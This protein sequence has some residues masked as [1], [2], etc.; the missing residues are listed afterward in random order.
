M[1]SFFDWTRRL[2]SYLG[3]YFLSFL[4][5]LSFS[6]L[7]LNHGSW[8]F[9]QFWPQRRVSKYERAVSDPAGG[10]TDRA[11]ALMAQIGISGEVE[12]VV[13]EQAPGHL[14]FRVVRPG[15]NYEVDADFGRGAAAVEET[16]VNAWGVLNTLHHLNGVH[17]GDARNTRDWFATSLWVFCMDALAAGLLFIAVSGI[18]IWLY[19]GRRRLFG[20]ITLA[21]GVLTCWLLLFPP[22]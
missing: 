16:K 7:V 9:T 2:H 11:R 5:L 1:R 17:V 10:E 4:W 6:G 18:Y 19:T 3:L 13:P 21:A 8:T 22:L 12:W 14:R 15:R 20:W